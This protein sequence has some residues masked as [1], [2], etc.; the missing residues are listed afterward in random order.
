MGELLKLATWGRHSKQTREAVARFAFVVTVSF[1]CGPAWTEEPRPEHFSFA[2]PGAVREV[3]SVCSGDSCSSFVLL[4]PRSPQELKAAKKGEL[5]ETPLELWRLDVPNGVVTEPAMRR[6]RSN[7]PVDAGRLAFCEGSS[8]GS[9]QALLMFQAEGSVFFVDVEDDDKELGSGTRVGSDSWS[10]PAR[11]WNKSCSELL[12]VGPGEARLVRLA[13]RSARRS[14]LSASEFPITLGIR[15]N[16]SGLTLESPPVQRVS[17]SLSLIVVGPRSYDDLRLE[18]VAFTPS[19]DAAEWLEISTRGTGDDSGEENAPTGSSADEAVLHAWSRLPA[20]EEVLSSR[21]LSVEGELVLQVVTK[22]AG[23]LGLLERK[24]LRLFRVKADRTRS[25]KLP[26]FEVLTSSRL[27]QR[28]DVQ[29]LDVTQDEIQDLVLVQPEG[30]SGEPT[31]VDVFVASAPLQFSRKKKRMVL[32]TGLAWWSV[33]QDWNGDGLKDFVVLDGPVVQFHHA[34]PGESAELSRKRRKRSV[35]WASEPSYRL[36]LDAPSVEHLTASTGSE[37]EV[38]PVLSGPGQEVWLDEG[39]LVIPTNTKGREVVYT[40]EEDMVGIDAEERNL[41]E[42]E[43]AAIAV[44]HVVR[45][46]TGSAGQR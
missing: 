40:S 24:K 31:L 25:G 12:L 28:L 20:Q 36:R 38:Q 41:T 32:Q 15:R 37:G 4:D 23:K 26:F 14:V 3:K 16:S 43:Q 10:S 30:L 11:P 13:G 8:R 29:F 18:S 34:S 22:E 39:V 1:V 7:I 46:P 45:A 17:E 6:L 42:E 21:Y 27:W 35:F 2:V 5:D 19:A 44:I 33:T 9:E